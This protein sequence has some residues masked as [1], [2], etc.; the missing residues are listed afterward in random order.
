VLVEYLIPLKHTATARGE[1]VFFDIDVKGGEKEW[2]GLDA[3]VGGPNRLAHPFRVSIN[4]KGGD[5]WHV[6][7]KSMLVIDG[8]N[9][10]N[11]G[12]SIGKNNNNDNMLTVIDGKNNNDKGMVTERIVA[13]LAGLQLGDNNGKQAGKEDQQ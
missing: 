9:N 12:M 11:D 6:Y 2:S 10:N 1:H 4:A 8:K 7:K 3:T 5:C 13:T